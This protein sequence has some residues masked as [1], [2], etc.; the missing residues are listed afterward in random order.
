MKGVSRMSTKPKPKTRQAEDLDREGRNVADDTDENGAEKPAEYAFP[1][2]SRC[3]RC[4]S[5]HTEAY[6]TKGP[7]QYRRCL[8]PI[9]R[10]RYSQFGERV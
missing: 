3:P 6:S 9:C 10:H 1:T 2:R 5:T 7:V 4:G 8:A